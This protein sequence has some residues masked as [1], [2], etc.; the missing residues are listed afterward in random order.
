[1]RIAAL[2]VLLLAL[3][4][5][6]SAQQGVPSDPG[7]FLTWALS[8]RI[9]ERWAAFTVCGSK[10]STWTNNEDIA[11]EERGMID[12]HEKSHRDF[13]ASFGSCYAWHL[14][15][16][17]SRAADVETEARAFCAGALHDYRRGRYGWMVAVQ[18]GALMFAGYYPPPW[19]VSAALDA[20]LLYCPTP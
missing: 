10:P 9:Q 13:M 14:W 11:E 20:M 15:H 6:A 12:A 4:G 1:M 8:V 5:P 3:A 17:G 7:E 18:Q 19:N 2:T 16:H